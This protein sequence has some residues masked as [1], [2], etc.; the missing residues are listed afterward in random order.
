MLRN[1]QQVEA[2]IQK[3]EAYAQA[4]SEVYD[5]TLD[6]L[7]VYFDENEH[8]LSVNW[9]VMAYVYLHSI[10]WSSELELISKLTQVEACPLV[11]E[12]IG[13]LLITRY[14]SNAEDMLLISDKMGIYEEISPY[15]VSSIAFQSDFQENN[16]L[17]I[18]ALI[19]KHMGGSLGYSFFYKYI[20]HITSFN[21]E[22]KVIDA[23]IDI[24]LEY[25]NVMLAQISSSW[26]TKAPNYITCLQEWID[27][28]KRE[29]CET[30]L[31]VI[32]GMGDNQ[33]AFENLYV[34]IIAIGELFPELRGLLVVT[35]TKYILRA[36]EKNEIY[37]NVLLELEIYLRDNE[38]KI[39]FLREL[40]HKDL[41]DDL[42]RIFEQV[43]SSPIDADESLN[44]LI[45]NIIFFNYKDNGWQ[46]VLANLYLAYCNSKT[47]K[48]FDGFASSA[49]QSFGILPNNNMELWEYILIK[50]SSEHVK[51]TFWAIG[52]LLNNFDL[53]TEFLAQIESCNKVLQKEQTQKIIVV[54][55]YTHH[56]CEDTCDLYFRLSSFNKNSIKEYVSFGIEKLYSLYPHTLAKIAEKYVECGIDERRAT[57]TALLEHSKKQHEEHIAF[58]RIKDFWPSDEREKIY[59]K[60]RIALQKEIKKKS[61]EK[62]F[63]LVST[64]HLKYGKRMGFI[65]HRGKNQLEYASSQPHPFSYGIEMP[66]L[67][68]IDPVQYAVNRINIKKG[69]NIDEVDS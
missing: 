35:L 21:Y 44:G 31:H 14:A 34:R 46:S 12:Y 55:S 66:K 42:K 6:E 60:S 68:L 27:T 61:S 59:R 50:L 36:V 33:K 54:L 63:F 19:S 18:L 43:I 48:D 16:I 7:E 32:N 56:K 65:A 49:E 8:D 26:A 29:K 2:L 52:L 40:S 13:Y 57:A 5:M 25:K 20:E 11:K 64:Q 53:N 67:Y 38:N 39:S 28:G 30:A 37:I 51:D 10:K 1:R 22:S 41:N 17:R 3:S 45:D 47:E 23:L 4:H 69:K 15:F 24:D 9:V 62:S 58:T